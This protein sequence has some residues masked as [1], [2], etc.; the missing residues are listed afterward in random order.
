[1]DL[2][3]II[4]NSGQNRVSLHKS[5]TTTLGPSKGGKSSFYAQMPKP[6]FLSS[7]KGLDYQNVQMVSLP[8]GLSES[9][10][11]V[12]ATL[13][14][15]H[16]AKT[17]PFECIV[18][19]RIDE[20]YNA[21]FQWTCDD[22]GIDH[23]SKLGFGKGWK[24]IDVEFETVIDQYLNIDGVGKHFITLMALRDVEKEGM[25]YHVKATNLKEKVENF[26]LGRCNFV[27][28]AITGEDGVPYL[29]CKQ[30]KYSVCCSRIPEIPETFPND[31][32]RLSEFVDKVHKKQTKER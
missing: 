17:L 10:A 25:K 4:E 6:M 26:I 20:I 32:K 16:K 27:F 12:K 30:D 21:C 1:V 31:Y 5:I 18:F 9:W 15:I 13:D 23:P 22:L 7:D 24:A 2:K 11:K 29:S 19:D 28:L 3:D 14:L 8:G